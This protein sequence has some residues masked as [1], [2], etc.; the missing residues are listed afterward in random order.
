MSGVVL[1][2]F[3]LEA[4]CSRNSFGFNIRFEAIVRSVITFGA[5]LVDNFF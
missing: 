5:R 2:S 1:L 4:I 3:P